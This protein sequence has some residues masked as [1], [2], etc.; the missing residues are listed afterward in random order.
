MSIEWFIYLA[1][2]VDAL[3][4]I[5]FLSAIVWAATAW[6]YASEFYTSDLRNLPPTKERIAR[7]IRVSKLAACIAL[8]A[9]LIPSGR[10]IYMIA[11][12]HLGKEVM[13]N[14]TTKK[15]TEILN[16]KLDEELAKLAN[17]K[18]VP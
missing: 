7:A 3:T 10:T 5:M 1:S 16:L 9:I 11:G 15:V 4:V 14:E 17:E 13:Q 8:I 2:I 6:M 18:H 12:A